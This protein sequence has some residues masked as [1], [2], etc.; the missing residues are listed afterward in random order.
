VGCCG[1]SCCRGCAPRR[2]RW[3]APHDVPTQRAACVSTRSTGGQAA[4]RGGL[5]Q[6]GAVSRRGV[7][8][9]S[10]VA[11]CSRRAPGGPCPLRRTGRRSC[12]CCVRARDT[13][14]GGA[15]P[16]SCQRAAQPAL[17]H[18]RPGTHLQRG[19]ATRRVRRR[20]A[21]AGLRVSPGC[22]PCCA[23]C[24][25]WEACAPS[26]TSLTCARPSSNPVSVPPQAALPACRS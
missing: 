17:P 19:R 26:N 1:C 4:R 15:H 13:R 20:C 9:A 14:R 3:R 10:R 7:S 16:L 23:L 25:A 2:W 22:T 18:S 6:R 12:C 11:I 21:A 5:S 8:L 24:V